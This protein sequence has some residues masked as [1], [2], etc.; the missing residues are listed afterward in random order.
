M[1][2]IMAIPLQRK[3]QIQVTFNWIF[4]LIAGAIILLFF[5]T[6]INREKDSSQVQIAQKASSRLDALFSVIQQNPNAIQVHDA[7]SY[8]MNFFCT[9]EGHYYSVKDG[10]TK[11][12]LESNPIFAP[13]T[14]GR[15]KLISWTK[16]FQAPYPT[17]PVLYLS[18]EKNRYIF[19]VDSQDMKTIYEDFPDKFSKINVTSSEFASIKD[20]GFRQ[21]IIITEENPSNNNIPANKQKILII[22]KESGENIYSLGTLK[23]K[24]G[25]SNTLI[26]KKYVNQ[27]L[28]FAGIIT[29]NP[30]LYDCGLNKVLKKTQI[31][32]NMNLDRIGKLW[33]TYA[34]YGT[35]CTNFY[36]EVTRQYLNN[37]SSSSE[38]SNFESSDSSKNYLNFYEATKDIKR[39]NELIL[40]SDCTLLY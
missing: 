12:Y 14:L 1:V 17:G 19:V 6:A 24:S 30:E 18:D 15:S 9:E 40:R 33:E 34:D 8:E 20:D 31:V 32:T 3:A 21:Y 13:E 36:G 4:I 39:I 23:F 16:S 22:E 5:I 35:R 26:E 28:L 25:N 27:E 38:K 10:S 11:N 2:E 29:G 37:I 7:P